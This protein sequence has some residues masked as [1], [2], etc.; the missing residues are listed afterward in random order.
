MMRSLNE[1]QG[2]YHVATHIP[3]GNGEPI[4]G[5][6]REPGNELHGPHEVAVTPNHVD[7]CADCRDL[8]PKPELHNARYSHTNTEPDGG[9]PDDGAAGDGGGGYGV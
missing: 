6:L 3:D 2:I 4:C 1:F 9:T 7:V 5:G 8:V